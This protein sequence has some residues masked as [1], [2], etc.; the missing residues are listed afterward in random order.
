MDN[1]T[2]Y[3]QNNETI[4]YSKGRLLMCAKSLKEDIFS[5]PQPK[6]DV[7][8]FLRFLDTNALPIIKPDQDKEKQMVLRVL[9][10]AQ[11]CDLKE[12]TVPGKCFLM[13]LIY[14]NMETE[15][16]IQFDYLI[17]FTKETNVNLYDYHVCKFIMHHWKL[18]SCYGIIINN[19]DLKQQ[20]IAK[21]V[22]LM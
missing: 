18:F 15:F 21:I 20:H 6:E 5:I 16:S 2:I 8:M 3:C 4:D 13:D 1:I 9:D 11:F 7:L 12:S 14:E 19:V 17:D 22:S 10:I